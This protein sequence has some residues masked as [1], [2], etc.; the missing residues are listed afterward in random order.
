MAN[1]RS[2][3]LGNRPRLSIVPKEDTELTTDVVAPEQTDVVEIAAEIAADL[4]QIVV[5]PDVDQPPAEVPAP[6][7]EKPADEE[8][9]DD[10]DE[11]PEEDES[12][13]TS[14]P[15][16]SDPNRLRAAELLASIESTVMNAPT[17]EWGDLLL[18]IAAEAALLTPLLTTPV[19]E[20][21]AC[22][23][24]IVR[25][26]PPVVHAD[27][28]NTLITHEVARVDAEAALRAQVEALPDTVP[29]EFRQTIL[30]SKLPQ[31]AAQ[32]ECNCGAAAKAKAATT[33]SSGGGSGVRGERKATMRMT[34]SMSKF[35]GTNPQTFTVTFPETGATQ[36]WEMPL[37][38]VG[39]GEKV[40][41]AQLAEVKRI[42]KESADWAVAQGASPEGQKN[43]VSKAIRDNGYRIGDLAARMA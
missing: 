32:Y 41:A 22:R 21:D 19:S 37:I 33:R 43:A 2:R 12:E 5:E 7:D 35:D 39:A 29:D 14:L 34:T 10:A 15:T 24:K 20:C 42:T 3:D 40:T 30:D 9:A 6:D 13:P 18:A 26:A 11:E 8:P 23:G 31:I 4:E 17:E 25:D 16:T 27:T 28:C 1:R 36:S 38:P